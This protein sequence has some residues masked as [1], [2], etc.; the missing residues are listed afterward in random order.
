MEFKNN[1]LKIAYKL[2]TDTLILL[3]AALGIW[4]VSDGVLPGLVSAHFSFTKLTLLIFANLA[5][6]IYLGRKNQ[7]T[8]SA[9]DFRRSKSAFLLVVFSF[10]LLGNS[11]LKFSYWE[12]IIITF[13]L[14][15]IFYFFYQSLFTPEK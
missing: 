2:L 6:L 11:L 13:S 7:L 4:L 3:L 1:T 15:A 12:N 10:F 14:L 9:F 5:A 8:F